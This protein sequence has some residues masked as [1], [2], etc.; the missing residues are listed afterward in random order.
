[1]NRGTARVSGHALA[2]VTP[3]LAAG[4]GVRRGWGWV[5]RAASFRIAAAATGRTAAGIAVS[6]HAEGTVVIDLLA[7]HARPAHGELRVLGEDMTTASG[8][9]AVR[10]RVGVAR[11]SVKPQP[12]VRIRGMVEHAARLTGRPA[13]DRD[14]LVA[15]IMDRLA[16]T[17]WAEV[18]MRAA[19]E[20]ICRRARLAAA[21]VHQPDLLLLDS[22]LD[23]L[24][25]RDVAALA[26]AIRDLGRD[27]AIVASGC[28]QS[29]LGLICDEILT[30]AY[31]IIVRA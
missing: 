3:V 23:D 22:L 21:A 7:G 15:V 27:T 24:V 18:P 26:D 9:A 16:L 25:A 5:L 14:L 2:A 6:S 4:V 1:M 8:R 11:R 17:P 13:S 29:A 12:A 10:A 30:L 28:D 19:P 20:L 31:G